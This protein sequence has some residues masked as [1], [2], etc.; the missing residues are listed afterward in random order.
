MSLTL[1]EQIWMDFFFTSF[2]R[3]YCLLRAVL[4]RSPGLFL[5]TFLSQS[6]KVDHVVRVEARTQMQDSEETGNM[7]LHISC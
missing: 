3:T 5:S 4:W 7:S 2:F 6:M 1:K